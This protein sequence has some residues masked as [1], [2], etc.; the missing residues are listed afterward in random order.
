MI[1]ATCV[2]YEACCP[3]LEMSRERVFPFDCIYISYHMLV[4]SFDL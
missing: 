4:L 3:G 1:S 2:D